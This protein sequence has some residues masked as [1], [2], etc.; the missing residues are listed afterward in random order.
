MR[1]WPVLGVPLAIDCSDGPTAPGAV[2]G[3]VRAIISNAIADTVSGEARVDL[4]GEGDS[5][6]LC[7]MCRQVQRGL[8]AAGIV[9]KFSD[10]D[11][12]RGRA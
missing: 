1:T 10:R 5:P 2:R 3:T 9:L 11:K 6:A 7:S 8:R 4:L 12:K